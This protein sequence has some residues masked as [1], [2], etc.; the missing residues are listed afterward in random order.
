MSR[1]ATHQP[2]P[3]LFFQTINSYQRAEALKAAIEID[4]ATAAPAR[5]TS[6]SALVW[7]PARRGCQ[8]ASALLRR[9]SMN[10]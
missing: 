1:P 6:V 2:T 8:L 10:C 5:R 7:R 3:Q 9:S 4:A